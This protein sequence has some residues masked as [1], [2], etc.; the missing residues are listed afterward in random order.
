[1]LSRKATLD[2]SG[3]V[4][5]CSAI[6]AE[7]DRTMDTVDHFAQHTLSLTIERLGSLVGGEAMERLLSF[8]T[9]LLRQRKAEAANH[10]REAWA[11]AAEENADAGSNASEGL[12]PHAAAA[13]AQTTTGQA[14]VQAS[15]EVARAAAKLSEQASACGFSVDAYVRRYSRHTRPWLGFHTDRSVV[16]VNV[17]LA[18]DAAHTGGR[19]H[20]VLGGAHRIVEREEGEAT[21]HSDDVMHGVSAMRSGVRYSLVMLFFL[22]Q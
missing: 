7:R 12:K 21:V 14:G 18:A 16:T 8:P 3:C 22:K 2:R 20:A 13:R 17:A 1:M 9:A 11:V 4:A 19:L 5:L 15:M 6:D 10:L